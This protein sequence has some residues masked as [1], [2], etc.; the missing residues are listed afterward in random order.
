MVDYP[1]PEAAAGTQLYDL[2]S[3]A[4]LARERQA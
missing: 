3:M 2:H 4:H 1:E